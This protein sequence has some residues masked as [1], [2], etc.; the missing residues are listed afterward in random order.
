[1]TLREALSFDNQATADVGT[2]F[3]AASA[4]TITATGGRRNGGFLQMSVNQWGEIIRD[5]QATWYC[6][7]GFQYPAGQASTYMSVRDGTTEHVVFGIVAGFVT[8]TRMPGTLLATSTLPVQPGQW[9]HLD[10]RVT[11][12]DAGGRVVVK[13]NGDTVIDFTGDTRNGANAS[14]DRVRLNGVGASYYR[15]DDVVLCDANGAV[16]NDHPGDCAVSGL[17]PNGNGTTSQ[18]VGSDGN[19]VDNYLLVDDATPATA[20][21]V[22]SST[23]GDKDTYAYPAPTQSAGTVLG[24]VVRPYAHKTD[25][26]VRS[27]VSVARLAAV[28]VDSAAK[29]LNATPTYLPDVRE[30]KPGGGAWALGDFGAGAAEFGVKVAA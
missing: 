18:L 20:D 2:L 1:M 26:G 14:A 22:E 19:S 16:N 12:A 23:V 10:H 21:Y 3:S 4:A 28:E 5:A 15:F 9:V 27:I 17:L 11:I 7:F 13:L 29:T 6:A 25:A 30:T 24:V 8:A